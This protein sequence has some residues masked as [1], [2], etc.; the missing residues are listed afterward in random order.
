MDTVKIGF[1]LSW[2]MSRHSVP[3]WKMLG[4]NICG[5]AK[6]V[7]GRSGRRRLNDQVPPAER[8]SRRSDTGSTGSGARTSVTKRTRGGF[9]GYWSGNWRRTW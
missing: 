2:M 7:A 9:A 1:H 6:G 4:W 3:S 5:E 8:S